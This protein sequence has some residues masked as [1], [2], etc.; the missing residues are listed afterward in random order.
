MS[1]H[2]PKKTNI[3]FT[4][5]QSQLLECGSLWPYKSQT[6]NK[7]RKQM[8]TSG[9]GAQ[10]AVRR[11]YL[12]EIHKSSRRL[13]EAQVYFKESSVTEKKVVMLCW[14]L[15]C[16]C[17][18]FFKRRK[19]KAL[20]RHKWK[21]ERT[22]GLSCHHLFFFLS[23]LVSRPRHITL[24]FFPLSS[25]PTPAPCRPSSSTVGGPVV[26]LGSAGLPRHAEC[27]GQTNLLVVTTLGRP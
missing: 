23:R 16:R 17:C 15:C 5:A 18:C 7:T 14:C 1:R 6:G 19:R 10:C 21:R 24:S 11:Q 9:G 20:Q 3:T 8:Q 4:S 13:Q 26:Y 2:R 25:A 27:V 22:L 12:M